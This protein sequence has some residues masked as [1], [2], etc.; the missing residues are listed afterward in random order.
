MHHK[1]RHLHNHKHTT[2]IVNK[3]FFIK[4]STK[5]SILHDLRRAQYTKKKAGPML[6]HTGG[7]NCPN[8]PGGSD[9]LDLIPVISVHS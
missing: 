3:P 1:L 9:R 8:G 7:I 6:K 4:R 2:I 5:L